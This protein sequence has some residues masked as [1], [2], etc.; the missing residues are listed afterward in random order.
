MEDKLSSFAKADLNDYRAQFAA[1]ESLPGGKALMK[2]LFSRYVKEESAPFLNDLAAPGEVL[3]LTERYPNAKNPYRNGFVH[4]RVKAYAASG[5]RASVFCMDMLSEPERYEFDGVT[6][7]VGCRAELYAYLCANPQVKTVCIHFFNPMMW[8]VL[9]EFPGKRLLIWSHGSDI[10]PMERRPFLYHTR[11]EKAFGK[12]ESEKRMAFWAEIFAKADAGELDAQF[13]YVSEYLKQLAVEDHG[14]LR[15][16]H[17]R[18]HVIPNCIDTNL[19]AY[20]P[21]QEEQRLKLLSVR[22]FDNTK[23][24]NDLT[25][26]AILLLSKEPFFDKL[27]FLIAGNGRLFDETVRPL[28]KF[29][30]VE[31]HKGYYSQVELTRLYREYGVNIQPTRFDTQGVSRDEAF[32]CGMAVI[33]TNCSCVPEFADESCAILTPPE[34]P[35]A[36]A[37]GVKRLFEKPEEFLRLSANARQRALLLSPERTT[38]RELELICAGMAH[39]AVLVQ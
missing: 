16:P 6:V 34:D 8:D 9:K 37:A 30:N 4:R 24:A 11:G 33:T 17:L 39:K 35:A 7:T 27:Q 14:L 20:Q 38:A 10:L 22:S 2:L 13:I 25:V 31:L 36:I 23:Y 12:R 29:R 28:K 21:K 18:L 15:Y 1:I 32:S 5:V 26:Q 3:V 19:F